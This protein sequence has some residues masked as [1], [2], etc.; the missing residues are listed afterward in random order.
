[1]PKMKLNE[2][3]ERAVARLKKG[4]SVKFKDVP[5]PARILD[6]VLEVGYPVAIEFAA[7]IP[8]GHSCEKRGKHGHCRWV[9][10][11]DIVPV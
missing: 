7:A 4:M 3:M 9:M 11:G 6:I 5:I 10:P 2:A 8:G 1:M